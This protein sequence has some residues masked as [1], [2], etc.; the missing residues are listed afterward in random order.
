MSSCITVAGE[1]NP[2]ADELGGGLEKAAWQTAAPSLLPVPSSA[3][4]S[5][6]RFLTRVSCT[7][8]LGSLSFLVLY[9]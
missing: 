6:A 8:C 7:P 3:P 9:P 4:W 1:S 5:D 2:L